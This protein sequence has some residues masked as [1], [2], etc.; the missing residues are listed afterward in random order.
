MKTTKSTAGTKTKSAAT[1]TKSNKN[2][3]GKSS[4][5][6]GLRELFEDSLKDIYWAE[7]ALTKALPKMAKNATSENLIST[8]NDH[9]TVTEEQVSRLEQVFELIGKKASAKKCDAMEG[10]IKEGESI[11]EETESGPVRDAGIIA[12]SQ[13]IEHYEIAS[14][15]T[16]AAFAETLGEED[17]LAL[18]QQTLEEEKEADTLL[19]DVAYNNINFEAAE[20]DDEDDEEA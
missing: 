5:A 13:K 9:L 16:L 11:I 17:A 20:E 15:G 1:K 18:L 19:T 2:T 8:L 4:A 7:K 12:A 14:Y 10:L 6:E 3:K